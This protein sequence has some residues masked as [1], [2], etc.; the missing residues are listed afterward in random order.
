MSDLALDTEVSTLVR[1]LNAQRNHVIG[2]L[3][4]LDE[5]ALRQPILPS[6]WSCL[7]MVQHLALDVEKFWFRAV[8]AGEHTAI[9]EL[10]DA[11]SAWEIS[12]DVPAQ[13]ILDQYQREI[14][15][16]NAVITATPLDAPP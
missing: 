7:S 15:L 9:E 2:I 16:A 10:A 3:N 4:G 13:A 12:G 14:E 1:Y 11:P 8:V 5:E 6:G